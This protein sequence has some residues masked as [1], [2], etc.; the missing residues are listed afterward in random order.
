MDELCSP[1]KYEGKDILLKSE[2]LGYFPCFSTTVADRDLFLNLN[3]QLSSVIPVTTLLKQQL[4]RLL[5]L[6]V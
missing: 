1:L 2:H 4:K 3:E 6:P 5:L